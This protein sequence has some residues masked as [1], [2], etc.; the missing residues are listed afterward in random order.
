LEGEI[1]LSVERVLLLAVSTA[2]RDIVL[3][4]VVT[5]ARPRGRR[6]VRCI[7]LI[8]RITS[9]HEIKKAEQRGLRWRE[10]EA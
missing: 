8:K 5:L 3:C 1:P 9:T 10:E 7:L 2:E 6:V 4:A